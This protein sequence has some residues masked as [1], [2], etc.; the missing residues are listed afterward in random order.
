MIIFVF[1][2]Y[3]RVVQ[4][5]GQFISTS[6]HKGNLRLCGDETLLPLSPTPTLETGGAIDF[7]KR[8]YSC[9]ERYGR[10]RAYRCIREWVEIV[11]RRRDDFRSKNYG[12]QHIPTT[13]NYEFENNVNKLHQYN[14]RSKLTSSV[15]LYYCTCKC[16]ISIPSQVGNNARSSIAWPAKRS[17]ARPAPLPKTRLPSFESEIIMLG[18]PFDAV[19]TSIHSRVLS[20][21][22]HFRR[23]R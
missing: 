20:L 10:A 4:N 11:R 3:R 5:P 23:L 21:L 8:V 2:Y 6:C 17:T 7:W 12:D 18:C 14:R 22:A 1:L 19:T 16:P 13:Q 15:N 9:A